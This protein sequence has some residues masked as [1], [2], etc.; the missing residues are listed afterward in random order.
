MNTAPQW[1][2]P[3]RQLTDR[4]YDF[5]KMKTITAHS[6]ATHLHYHDAIEFIYMVDGSVKLYIDGKEDQ[7]K[8]GD[9]ALFRSN[10]VHSMY[11]Q[12]SKK[13]NYYVLKILPS[14]LHSI[15][16]NT[17]GGRFAFRFSVFNPRLKS[18]WRR[19]ELSGSGIEACFEKLIGNYHTPGAI[20]DLSMI[21]A[22][23]GVLEQIYIETEKR[24]DSIVPYT[25][26]IYRA[27]IYV[28]EHFDEDIREEDVAS[29]FG[30]SYGY[31]S[32][33]FKAVTGGNFR[34]YLIN[35]RINNAENLVV[36]T[37]MSIADIARR[38]GYGNISHFISQFKKIKNTTPLQMRKTAI[39]E[40]R[41]ENNG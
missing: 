8:R 14:L 26:L 9:L 13:N 34:D 37:N 39:S 23:L 21:V 5:F 29:E 18:V 32:R 30:L 19:E 17:L 36:N 25:D 7:L 16:P 4:G 2:N 1:E 35:V 24:F 22:A 10:G 38:C 27:I 40:A 6:L 12:S 20:S 31:F 33:S 41:E 28:N 11:T 3:K 15:S